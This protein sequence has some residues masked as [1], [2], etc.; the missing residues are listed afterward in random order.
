[1]FDFNLK[2]HI[3]LLLLV[4][5]TCLSFE[6]FLLRGSRV[7]L[8]YL[9]LSFSHA[10]VTGGQRSTFP[11]SQHSFYHPCSMLYWPSCI[12]SF[13][14]FA[15]SSSTQAK[16]PSNSAELTAAAGLPPVSPPLV[17]SA[18]HSGCLASH[19]MNSYPPCF[20]LYWPT[21]CIQSFKCRQ[22]FLN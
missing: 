3:L 6:F 18:V 1:M 8:L 12:Q 21:R 13:A 17:H 5:R 9:P 11:L 20:V 16:V 14:C 15:A 7:S 19:T 22:K 10:R 4:Q 2:L